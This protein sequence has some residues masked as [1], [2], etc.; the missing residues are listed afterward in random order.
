MLFDCCDNLRQ[1]LVKIAGGGVK[2]LRADGYSHDGILTVLPVA[3]GAL[4]VSTA[5]RFMLG[6]ITQV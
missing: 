3:V 5:V 4:A 6:V 1:H 2:Y